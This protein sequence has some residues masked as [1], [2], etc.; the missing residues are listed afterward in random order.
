MSRRFFIGVDLDD[1]TRHGL[2]AQLNRHIDDLPGT[3]SPPPNWH[4]TLRFVGPLDDLTRE[5]LVHELAEVDWPSVFRVRF[6]ELDAFPNHRRATVLWVG[7]KHGEAQLNRLAAL[8]ENAVRSCG[9]VPEQRPFVPHLTLS[10]V[11]PP[12]D[13]RRMIEAVP[14]FGIAM[15]VSAVH[16]FE[17]VAN[18]RR[19]PI[20]ESFRLPESGKK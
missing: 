12:V 9:I 8:A 7:L 4:L 13:V 14:P 15:D 10:R 19:Y 5:R 18:P 17:S 20:V 6:G 1:E 16:L 2:V 11:R 3:P